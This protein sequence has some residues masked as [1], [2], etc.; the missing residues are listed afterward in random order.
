MT[1]KYSLDKRM[2]NNKVLKFCLHIG[3]TRE[4][5]VP[6]NWKFKSWVSLSILCKLFFYIFCKL[7]SLIF[8]AKALHPLINFNV[9]LSS[10]L[11][12]YRYKRMFCIKE[13]ILFA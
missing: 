7:W 8:C 1:V 5:I 2:Y 12:S 10:I 3:H 11:R 6:L 4:K 13:N 9:Y